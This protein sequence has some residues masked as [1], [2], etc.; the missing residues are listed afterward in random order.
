MTI[1][2][3]I[4]LNCLKF[5]SKIGPPKLFNNCLKFCPNRPELFILKLVIKIFFLSFFLLPQLL[6]QRAGRMTSRQYWCVYQLHWRPQPPHIGY[7]PWVWFP[8]VGLPRLSNHPTPALSVWTKLYPRS[9]FGYDG[10]IV[11]GARS[12]HKGFC[13][14]GSSGARS[15]LVNIFVYRELRANQLVHPGAIYIYI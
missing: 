11:R 2:P 1:L 4:G 6:L 3:Q 12:I 8:N 7:T 14:T 9:S 13:N 5:L 15:K 10:Q